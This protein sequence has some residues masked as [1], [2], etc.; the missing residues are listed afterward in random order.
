[1]KRT[2]TLLILTF[3]IMPVCKNVVDH[4]LRFDFADQ[5]KKEA[6]AEE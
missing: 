5:S 4:N 2:I 3:F 6:D 1:M